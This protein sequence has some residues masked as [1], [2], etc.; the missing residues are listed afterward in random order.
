MAA[1]AAALLLSGCFPYLTSYVHLEGPLDVVTP[2]PACGNAGPPVFARY[3]RRGVTFD[4]TLEPGIAARGGNG[5]LRVR[6]PEGVAVTIPEP[7]GQ[8]KVYDGDAPMRFRLRLAETRNVA[9]A[10]ERRFEFDGLP[11]KIDFS[12]TLHLPDVLVDGSEVVSP[13]L[14]FRRH[15]Y[16]GVAPTNC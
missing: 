12:G 16:A 14:Q 8:L 2:Q 15:R 9:G 11:A 3:V 1:L 6:A 4:V 5:F 7:F 13:V 10:V